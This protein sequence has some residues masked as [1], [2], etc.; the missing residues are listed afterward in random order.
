[1]SI[2]RKSRGGG[3]RPSCS[4]KMKQDALPQILLK[5]P[6]FTLLPFALVAVIV[7]VMFYAAYRAGA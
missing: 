6:D 1:M 7:I 3:Q 5:L 4:A 2:T